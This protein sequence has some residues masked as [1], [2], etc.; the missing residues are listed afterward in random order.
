MVDRGKGEVL[1]GK[2]GEDWVKTRHCCG[3]SRDCVDFGEG[4]RRV[5]R[6]RVSNTQG[7]RQKKR[8]KIPGR[9]GRANPGEV[10]L[11]TG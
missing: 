2:G 4:M 1:G 7:G 8:G 10:I 5:C 11:M 6:R 3:Y 9:E